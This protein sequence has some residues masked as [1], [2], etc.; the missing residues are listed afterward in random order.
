MKRATS[1]L[2][3]GIFLAMLA[4]MPAFGAQWNAAVGA[5]SQDKGR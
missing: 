3:L 1:K 5:Q 2:F 4:T